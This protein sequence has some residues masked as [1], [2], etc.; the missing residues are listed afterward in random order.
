MCWNA[1]T[2]IITF[3]LGT[4]LNIYTYNH[5]QSK[6]IKLICIIWQWILS[7]QLAEFI[8]WNSLETN[9]DKQNK[10]GTKLA[11]ILNILQPV[12]VYI[13]LIC[14]SSSNIS[15]YKKIIASIIILLY[16]SYMLLKFNSVPEYTKLNPSEKCINM[17]LKWWNDIP[18]S[19]IIYCFTLFTLIL[20]LLPLKLGIITSLYIFIAL[21]IS[22]KFYS[23]GQPSIWCWLVVP[24]PIIIALINKHL[25]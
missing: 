3:I 23:C 5:F 18:I 1:Q 4:I 20:L 24:M 14:F 7:M 2:S 11:L 6:P 17:N 8:I 25:L 22:Q 19:G 21:F 15:N 9:N 12:V 16:I 10:I 13:V